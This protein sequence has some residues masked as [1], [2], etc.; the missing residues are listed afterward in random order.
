MSTVYD[1]IVVGSGPGGATVARGLARAGKKVL[2]LEKG[3]NHSCLGSYR[4][5]AAMLDRFGFFKS[6][7]GLA[8]L[9]VTTV[10]GATMLY[11]G[12]AA[13]P[14][15]WLKTKYHIDLESH[16][17]DICREL[18]VN[19][20]PPAYIGA[21][22]KAVMDA[23]NRIGQEW[24]P[25][26]KFID[27]DKVLSGQTQG[28][29]SGART[30]LGENFG[31]RWT[32]R[33]YVRDA[34]AAGATLIT[35]ADCQGVLVQ[36]NTVK[37]VRVRI[38]GKATVTFLADTVILSAGGIP[39]PV[40]LKRAGI[41][42]AGQGCVVDPTVLVYGISPG[43]GTYEDPLVSVVSWKWYD[44]EGIRVGTLIDPWVMTMVGLA[45]AGINHL[46]K[47]LKYRN[48]IGILVKIKDEIGGWVDERGIVSKAL[49]P[50]DKE[51]L[52][53]GIAI[54]RD[55]LV[56]AGCKKNTI[57]TGQIRGAHPSGTCRI[58]EVVNTDLETSVKNLFVCD[59]SIFPEALDRP[60]VV[61]IIA[62][63]RRLVDH[64]LTRTS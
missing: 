35:Q 29:I 45:Q 15:S 37:G 39:S 49:T 48:M 10:G 16:A 4:G 1:A 6:K 13:M 22:S 36:D 55:V 47:I 2:L 27:M 12:S 51:K 5:A 30:S 23:G 21:A 33:D 19:V 46:P 9:K 64:L 62:F 52:D 14:P 42:N 11:S 25:M 26:P 50:A 58:G 40:L 18:N 17:Q 53:K 34:K 56:E 24:E 61:T 44:K 31:E 43:K 3:K 32:A 38:N 59:A 20:L 41:K 7:E 8:M 28:R 60:T 57:V 63:G 54:A